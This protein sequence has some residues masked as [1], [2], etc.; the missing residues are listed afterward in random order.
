M[1]EGDW[2]TCTCEDC[3][4]VKELYEALEFYWDNKEEKEEIERKIESM[5]YF[6]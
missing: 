2:E 1:C 4:E 3:K 5:G 6:I